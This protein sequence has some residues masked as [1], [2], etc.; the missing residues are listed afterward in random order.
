MGEVCTLPFTL[1]GGYGVHL[2]V[3]W[4]I[5]C[6]LFASCCSGRE[7]QGLR[8]SRCTSTTSLRILTGVGAGLSAGWQ[9]G[10]GRI[11]C[12]TTTTMASARNL[13]PPPPT[14]SCHRHLGRRLRA[15]TRTA[16]AF[17]PRPW[18]WA[19]MSIA[20]EAVLWAV[21][22]TWAAWT[23]VCE[24][25]PP[26]LLLFTTSSWATNGVH[27]QLRFSSTLYL[28]FRFFHNSYALNNF[29]LAVQTERSSDTLFDVVWHQHS[30]WAAN[31]SVSWCIWW[32]RL[33]WY[34]WPPYSS[35]A[36]KSSIRCIP[37]HQHIWHGWPPYPSPIY[38]GLQRRQ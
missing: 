12:S 24:L 25:R 34:G 30:S 9:H 22:G 2:R 6:F 19:V 10:P 14:I 7:M 5:A 32:Y 35:W 23:E 17:H 15:Y 28:W 18:N 16:L 33:I 38:L 4:M 27:S 29:S 3:H 20:F 37:W 36:A 8:G 11:A 31:S 21:W 26:N 1:F 13:N